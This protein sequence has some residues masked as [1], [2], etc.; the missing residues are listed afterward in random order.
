MIDKPKVYLDTSVISHLFQ[1]EKPEA[2]GYTLEFWDKIKNGEFEVFISQIVLDEI[3]KA[4]NEKSRLMMA[5]VNEIK[6]LSVP[7]SKETYL[8]SEYIISQ[9][10]LPKSSFYDSVHVAAAITASCDYLATWN[11]KHL[12]SEKTNEGI[13]LITLK[14]NYA[15]LQIVAPNKLLGVKP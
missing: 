4:S 11:M 5:A 7:L 13:R 9:K 3:G 10:I 1:D 12:A 2:K 6:C 14:N 15:Q 8:L